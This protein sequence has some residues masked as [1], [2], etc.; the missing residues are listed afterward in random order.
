MIFGQGD[1]ISTTSVDSIVGTQVYEF[2]VIT[3]DGDTLSPSK[4]KEKVLLINIWDTVCPPCIAEFPS[5]I[6]LYT[7]YQKDGFEILGMTLSLYEDEEGLK[8]F[9][10]EHNLN[11]PNAKVSRS[12]IDNLGGTRGIPTTYIVGKDG[13]VKFRYFGYRSK[14]I[15][16]KDICSLLGIEI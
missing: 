13:F 5:F 1:G 4:Y 6:E 14:E 2:S 10:E 8:E 9:I 12:I 16:K 3:L 11:F 15:I 7:K